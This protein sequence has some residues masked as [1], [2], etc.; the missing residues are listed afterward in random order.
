VPHIIVV[1]VIIISPPLG[2]WFRVSLS[3]SLY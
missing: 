2:G 1:I 3:L